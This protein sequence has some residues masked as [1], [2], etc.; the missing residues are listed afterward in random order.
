[1]IKL[2]SRVERLLIGG[3]LGLP[4]PREED[5]VIGGIW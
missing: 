1:M 3:H 2:T 4:S 5:K